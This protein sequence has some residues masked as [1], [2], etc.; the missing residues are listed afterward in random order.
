MTTR[1]QIAKA[2]DAHLTKAR[3]A[4]KERR[5]RGEQPTAWDALEVLRS[6]SFGAMVGL[7]ALLLALFVTWVATAQA[8]YISAFGDE[9]ASGISDFVTRVLTTRQ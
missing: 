1:A 2:V 7:G 3:A 8:I 9:G 4:G 5:K 6:P